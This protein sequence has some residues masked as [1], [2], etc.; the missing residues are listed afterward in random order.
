MAKY[1]G[2]IVMDYGKNGKPRNYVSIV[3]MSKI[4]MRESKPMLRHIGND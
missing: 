4:R 2:S 1:K 3:N